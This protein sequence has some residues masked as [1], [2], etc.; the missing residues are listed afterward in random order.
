MAE[1][2]SRLHYVV[3]LYL[4]PLYFYILC[5]LYIIL[6]K[7]MCVAA[8]CF[9]YHWLGKG[10][11]AILWR[12]LDQNLV[13]FAPEVMLGRKAG[14][15][16]LK[17][18]IIAI[19]GANLSEI[20]SGFLMGEGGHSIQCKSSTMNF[21]AVILNFS[22][23]FKPHCTWHFLHV[24]LHIYSMCTPLVSTR[25]VVVVCKVWLCFCLRLCSIVPLIGK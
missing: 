23:K 21:R 8:Y 1:R 10:R 4:S 11:R 12:I 3:T 20:T 13:I 25:S 7:L 6:P 16:L 19:K 17:E 24:F 18:D 15:L 5:L 22:E 2:Y 14:R 9:W